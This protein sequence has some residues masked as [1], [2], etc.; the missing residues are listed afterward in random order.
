MIFP[1]PEEKEGHFPYL[2][3][4]ISEW[5]SRPKLALDPILQ[6]C[7]SVIISYACL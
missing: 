2:F 4:S 7:T 3:Y 6:I 5:Y 1:I